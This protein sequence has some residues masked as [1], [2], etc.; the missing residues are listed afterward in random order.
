MYSKLVKY[1][2]NQE[3]KEDPPEVKDIV[4]KDGVLYKLDLI[5]RQDT[6]LGYRTIIPSNF[7]G[8]ILNYFH[9]TLPN[10]HQGFR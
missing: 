8:D 7:V 1:L 4:F 2:E 6:V 3:N 5:P 10:G 9:C